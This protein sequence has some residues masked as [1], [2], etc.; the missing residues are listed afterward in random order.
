MFNQPSPLSATSPSARTHLNG[1]SVEDDADEKDRLGL[2][3]YN[4]NQFTPP[5][6]LSAYSDYPSRGLDPRELQTPSANDIRLPQPFA[7]GSN[8][9]HALSLY[10]STKTSPSW[11][12]VSNSGA[13]LNRRQIDVQEQ[14]NMDLRMQQQI[15]RLQFTNGYAPVYNPFALPGGDPYANMSPLGISQIEAGAS[16]HDPRDDDQMQSYVMYEFKANQKTRRYE[17]KDIFNH[18]LEFSGDQHGSRFIQT[19]LESANSDDK[20]RVF[21]EIEPNAIQLMTDVFGNYVIQKFFEHGDQR[22]KKILANKMK[23]EVLT[24]S[25]QMYGCRVVQKALDHVLVDQQHELVS[26]LE[27]HVVKCIKDQN[28]NHVIQ[29]AIERCPPSTIRFMIE[30][31]RGDV[32][33]L[34]IH[35]YGCRVIQRCLERCEPGPKQMIL[36]EL[37]ACIEALISD[38]YGNY[39]VQHVVLNDEGH[40]KAL[41]LD[42]VG[43]GLEMYSKHK[44]AS[45][46]VEKCL[47]KS[48]DDWRRKVMFTLANGSPRRAEGEGVFVCMIKD[49]YGNYVIRKWL[50]ILSDRQELIRVAE[51]LLDTLAPEDYLQFVD[52]LQ[53]ALSQAKRTGCGKQVLSIEKKMN[54]IP[55]FRGGPPNIGAFNPHAFRPV[56]GHFANAIDSANTTPPPPLTADTRSIQSSALQSIDGD[57]VEG[58]TAICNRKGSNQSPA[59]YFQ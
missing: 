40:A 37:M 31:F 51:K 14:L 16:P 50:G 45:N 1:S 17:L 13:G 46:V 49:S 41:V 53:P 12:P 44:F 24:L 33:H 58:A 30:A 8:L 43:R 25:L 29:K 27:G 35:P 47:E 15:L 32:Q 39:V 22:H 21:K 20:E 4:Q 23:G 6:Q 56:V 59:G 34:S 19:K 5:H 55:N 10:S 52:M 36:Q 48:T 42:I 3:Y 18:I 54:R 57:T 38:Q 28:G 26:E 9:P 11:P 7:N 2:N